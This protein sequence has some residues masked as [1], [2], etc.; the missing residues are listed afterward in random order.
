MTPLVLA[1]D[2]GGTKVLGGLVTPAGEVLRTTEAPTSA[3]GGA[4]PG[5]RATLEVARRLVSDA[6]GVG[7]IVAAGAGFP[8]Y[9]SAGELRSHEVLA[10]TDQPA[11]L[12][13]PVLPGVPWVV[14]S[15]VRCGAVAEAVLGAGADL[16]SVLYAAWGTGLSSTLVLGGQPHAGE[17]GEAIALGEFGV[18]SSVDAE[19]RD[20]LERFASGHG[21][22]ARYSALSGIHAGGAVD[23][24]RHAACGAPGAMAVLDSAGR[25]VGTALGWLVGVLDPAVV[26]LGGGLGSAET[27]AGDAAR[28]AYD[29]TVARRPGPP[30]L[31]PARLGAHAGLIG[32]ALAAVVQTR[33]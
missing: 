23:V 19:W 20:N 8:E 15:D 27:L 32:A 30:P 4:D 9:V 26:V 25:A 2:V 3:P 10:W 21:I 13:A 18:H 14:E 5:L 29:D 1:L 24:A 7:E 28:R 11:A 16:R 33:G 12:L 22:A 17:R 6:S 31:L